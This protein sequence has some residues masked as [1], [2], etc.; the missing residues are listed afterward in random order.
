VKATGGVGGP[1]IRAGRPAPA[2]GRPAGPPAW[3]A[4]T[5]TD[6]HVRAATRGDLDAIA[7]VAV[8]TGQAEEWSGS[9]PAY[10][11]HLLAEGRVMVAESADRVAGFGATRRIGDGPGAVTMLCDLFV[12]PG[13]HGGGTGQALLAALWEPGSPRMTFSSLHAHALPV[14]TRAGLD[15]WW[16]LLYL[17]GDVSALPR[18]PGWTVAPASPGEVAALEAEWTGIDRSADHRAW[19]ARPGGQPV[20][21]RFSAA[22]LAAG[23]VAG[24][25]A[26]YGIAHLALSPAAGDG[27]AVEAVMAVLASLNPPDSRA[28]VC[29]PGPH[30]AVRPLLAAG[31]HVDFMDI[32][33]ATDP[34]LLDPRRAIPS[35]AMA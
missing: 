34:G 11:T 17:G 24:E 27:E 21:A 1:L 13:S 35:P 26:E 25:G 28:R 10:V 22:T 33:M 12:D 3:Q 18:A 32:F 7:A 29:L 30:P 5:V 2:Q 15:A 4:V 14:Y 19:A 9:D 6:V 8:A 20:T 23:T 16:P 31:W